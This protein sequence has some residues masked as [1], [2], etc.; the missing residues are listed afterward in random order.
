MSVIWRTSGDDSRAAPVTL[1]PQMTGGDD[2]TGGGRLPEDRAP[3]ARA[4]A[5]A[6]RHLDWARR[7]GLARLAEEDDLD[8]RE[9][10]RR[11]AARA[12]W[13]HA[14]PRPPG[15]ALL[16]LVVG[17]QRSGTNLVLRSLAALPEVEPYAENDRRLF[18]RFRLRSPERLVARVHA[19][20]QLAVV[21]KPLCDSHESAALL[22]LFAGDP[23]P[24]RALWVW[25]EPDARAR[26][27]VAK[28]GAV[29]RDVL[30]RIAR[31][32]LDGSW[33]AGGMTPDIL[34][35]VRALDPV[36]LRPVDGAA[37]FWWVRNSLYF[38]TGLDARPEVTLLRHEDLVADPAG[39]WARICAA[40]GLPARPTDI[41]VVRLPAARRPPPLPLDPRVRAL[42]ADLAA[43]LRAAGPSA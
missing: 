17:V 11:R 12:R 31:D 33:Q 14:H 42:C 22:D 5:R 1:T 29:N 7:E 18:T 23:A 39:E 43:R 35:T 30:A 34:A 40:A 26:S 24:A 16:V 37:L 8:P 9:R 20:R 4:L 38:T 28:F 13:R 19:S 32:G 25:R 10:A 2:M 41:P 21:A 27:A 15:A 3:L 6:A 36:R